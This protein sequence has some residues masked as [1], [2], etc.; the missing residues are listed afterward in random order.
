MQMLTNSSRSVQD[1]QIGLGPLL[2]KRT[3]MSYSQ[4]SDVSAI[5]RTQIILIIP[6]SPFAKLS[7]LNFLFF[8]H[9]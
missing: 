1:Y 4:L 8:V 6:R 2:S 3:S 9:S 5:L 7:V